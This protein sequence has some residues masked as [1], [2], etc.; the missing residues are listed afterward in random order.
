MS[1]G[2]FFWLL[3][4]K[5]IGMKERQLIMVDHNQYSLSGVVYLIREIVKIIFLIE[6]IGGLI[7][8]FYIM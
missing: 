4:R 6:L 7:F 8:T 5:R 1:I 2:T 3:I